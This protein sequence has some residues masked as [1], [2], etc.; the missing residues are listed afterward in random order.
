MLE[1][2][3][4]IFSFEYDDEPMDD[5]VYELHVRWI[6]LFHDYYLRVEHVGHV[7]EALEIARK[8]HLIFISNH[9]ITIEATLINYYLLQNGAGHVGTLVYPEA[10][11]IPLVREF[12]RS[13][14]CVPISVEAGVQTLRKKHILLFPEGMDFISAFV[15]P[16]RVPR[17]HKGFLRMAKE[18]L[19]KNHKKH[20]YVVPIG[21]AGIENM[22][23]MWVIRNET[24][25]DKVVRPF[26]KYPFFVV[27]KMPFLLPSKTIVN[28]GMPTKITLEDLK[29]EKKISQKANYFRSTLVALKNRARKIREMKTM[30]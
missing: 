27:P 24:F 13:C 14:Q 1:T 2:L 6:K 20:L 26:A 23:K 7:K 29:N 12:F 11:K 8:E 22:M 4:K 19:K 18:S 28:W 30:E 3:Q 17:F 15:N 5:F 25:L 16:D 9:A 21:H 10:F